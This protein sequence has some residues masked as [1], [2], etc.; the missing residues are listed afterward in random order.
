[1]RVLV[2][3]PSPEKSKGGMATV[4]SEIRDDQQL[5]KKY[6]I[7]IDLLNDIVSE[8]EYS[9]VLDTGIIKEQIDKPLIEKVKITKSIK[10]FI[11]NL[12][13]RFK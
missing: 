7:D 8:Y 3:G 9:G 1:M 2:V 4:I 5:A 10:E 11:I 13:E 12:I 6:G